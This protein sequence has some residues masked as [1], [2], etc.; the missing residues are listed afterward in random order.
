MPIENMVMRSADEDSIIEL[1]DNFVLHIRWL[2]YSL[3]LP[4]LAFKTA[5]SLFL[6]LATKLLRVAAESEV[7]LAGTA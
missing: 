2:G 1:S 4:H 6:P 7:Y 3:A 5:R